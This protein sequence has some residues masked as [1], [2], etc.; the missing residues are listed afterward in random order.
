MK[1]E[2]KTELL[3]AVMHF[4]K[5]GMPAPPGERFRLPEMFILEKVS[6][7]GIGV[8][9]IQNDL[10]VT[11]PAVS[12]ILNILEHKGL[13]LRHTDPVDRRKVTVTLTE[14]GKLIKAKKHQHVNHIMDLTIER[15][16]E[17]N[18]RELIRLMKLLA[19]IS[20]EIKHDMTAQNGLCAYEGDDT[21]DKTV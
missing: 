19:E 9:E 10:S 6:E 16:G 21:I 14:A 17:D 11:K 13:I 7:E 20:N 8:T 18:T 5:V 1:A 12:Q 3:S 15:L 2:L 4:R